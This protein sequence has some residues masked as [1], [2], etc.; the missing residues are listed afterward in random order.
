MSDAFIAAARHISAE[1]VIKTKQN[2][3]KP[4]KTTTTKNLKQLKWTSCCS[5]LQ[6]QESRNV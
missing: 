6:Q 3:T 1:K 2:K 4:N 5:L